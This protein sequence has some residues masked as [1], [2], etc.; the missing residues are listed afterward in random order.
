MT[1]YKCQYCDAVFLQKFELNF[2]TDEKHEEIKP[3]KCTICGKG[4]SK[5]IYIRLGDWSFLNGDKT[6]FVEVFKH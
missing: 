2:H 3:H 1:E 6:N 4:F 5:A